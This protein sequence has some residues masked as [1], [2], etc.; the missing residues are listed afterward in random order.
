MTALN[1]EIWGTLF[2]PA[3]AV[4]GQQVFEVLVV[5]LI[6]LQKQYKQQTQ[7]ES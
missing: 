6:K 5:V 2:L 1:Q 4:A 7:D 3:S